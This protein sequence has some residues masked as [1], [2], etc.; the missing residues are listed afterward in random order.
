[1]SR[2]LQRF[3]DRTQILPV[4][5][6]AAFIVYAWALLWFFW[7]VPGWLYYLSVGD[8]LAALTY[9][10]ATNLAE[11]LLVLCAPLILA[12]ILPKRWFRDVFVARGASLC[13]AGLGYAMFLADT[14]KSKIDYPALS[15]HAW[16]VP[17]VLIAIALLVYAC[18]RISLVRRVLEVIADRATIF[19]YILV[20][21]S[22]LSLVAISVRS[23]VR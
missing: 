10:L 4:Y 13:I 21:A 6:V 12:A 9:V 3:P 2:I 11:S 17:V 15:L 7:K 14:F 18:G 23:L 22:L 20:P 5:A 1:M 16:T 8:V 19:V